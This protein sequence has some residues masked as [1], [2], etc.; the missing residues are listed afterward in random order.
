MVVVAVV[1]IVVLLGISALLTQK[2]RISSVTVLPS[3]KTTGD[4]YLKL[5]LHLCSL[6]DDS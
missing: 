2:V 4:A 6:P 1:D 3:H 5:I